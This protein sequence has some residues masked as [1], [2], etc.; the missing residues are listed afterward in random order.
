MAR[1]VTKQVP[2]QIAG[3]F[4]ESCARNQAG[5]TPKEI[6]GSDEA[7]PAAEKPTTPCAIAPT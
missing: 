7:S 1:H 3:Y 5:N 4:D 6:V 2:S